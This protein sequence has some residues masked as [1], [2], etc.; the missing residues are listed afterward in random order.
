MRLRPLLF[1]PVLLASILLMPIALMPAGCL[2][3]GTDVGDAGGSGAGA[4][5]TSEVTGSADGGP[6][7]AGCFADPASHVVLCEEVDL[8]PGVDVDPSAF[9]NCGF[10]LGAA[11]PLDL[12][13]ICG[14]SLCPLGVPN[15]CAAVTV[16]LAPQN[17]LLVCEQV[18]EGRCLPLGGGNAGAAAPTS[19]TCDRECESECAGAPSCIELCGC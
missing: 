13:C 2:R 3:I 1:S 18:D 19:G 9:P 16:L 15:T 14:D 5:P 17:A 12:E 6:T 10:R 11:S 7:G 8:C 4:S